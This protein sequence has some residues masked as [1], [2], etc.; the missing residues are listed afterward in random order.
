MV[1]GRPGGEPKKCTI[2]YGIIRCSHPA[3]TDRRPTCGTSGI[4]Y[5]AN[6]DIILSGHDHLYERFAPQD[7]DGRPDAQRGIRQFTLVPAAPSCTIS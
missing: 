1:E 5:D 3:Q 2:A 7:H 6:V 4:L